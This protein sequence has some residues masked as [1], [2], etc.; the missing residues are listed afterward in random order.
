MH[1]LMVNRVKRRVSC[2]PKATYYKPRE[3]PFY[4]LETVNLSIENLEALRLCD[5]LNV[6]QNDA[7]EMMGVSRKTFWN[8]LQK[9]RERVVDALVNGK[10]IEISGGEYINSS[11]CQ[12]DFICKGCEN[13]W[14]LQC[15]EGR[16]TICPKCGSGI[17]YRISGDGK[18]KRIIKNNYCCPKNKGKAEIN[19]KTRSV[20]NDKNCNTIDE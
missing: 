14:K 10:A 13:E 4:D 3:V 7:A 8:D 6:E 18:G 20:R 16:P 9:A 19:T 2:F 12:I 11:E 17:I 1:T 5:L 15:Y